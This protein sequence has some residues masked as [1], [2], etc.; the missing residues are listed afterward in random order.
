MGQT[1][2]RKLEKNIDYD[3]ALIQMEEFITELD[4][5]R[6][7]YINNIIITRTTNLLEGITESTIDTIAKNNLGIIDK[8]K[9]TDEDK[10][11]VENEGN[12]YKNTYNVGFRIN[13]KT[14]SISNLDSTN[15]SSSAS[16]TAS[17]ISSN[18]SAKQESLINGLK[19]ELNKYFNDVKMGAL[20]KSLVTDIYIL[21]KVVYNKKIHKNIK[22]RCSPY[23]KIK[24]AGV[25]PKDIPD[26]NAYFT[27]NTSSSLFQIDDWKFNVDNKN[28]IFELSKKFKDLVNEKN[29][30]KREYL[31]K[32]ITVA[33]DTLGKNL[34][35]T[36][37][38]HKFFK[39]YDELVDNNIM[40]N[41]Y[42]SSKTSQQKNYSFVDYDKLLN[43]S[44]FQNCKN[45]IDKNILENI[46]LNKVYQIK[47]EFLSKIQQNILKE[48][49]GLFK[50]LVD[51][52]DDNNPFE[53]FYENDE[54]DK[55]YKETLF[56][57]ILLLGRDNKSLSEIVEGFF[58]SKESKQTFNQ[59]NF[60]N[61]FNTFQIGILK[62]EDLYLELLNDTKFINSKV[63]R[64][65]IDDLYR[66]CEGSY[67]IIDKREKSN[68]DI[69][70][71]TEFIKYKKP[72]MK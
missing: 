72:I 11:N 49:Y 10:T 50:E 71:K 41:I 29:I 57:K 65:Y 38:N 27:N 63:E 24:K 52:S 61:Y 46:N 8:T 34:C 19:T 39:D 13:D 31:T 17:T 1:V 43:E 3:D 20:F 64:E 68:M 22:K 45:P 7:K 14:E 30:N 70:T 67:Q 32:E 28:R 58:E 36:Y 56:D 23:K 37:P 21:Y 15:A 16:T 4:N 55:K 47:I 9:M 69:K 40:P 51:Y 44:K 53:N 35:D 48:L 33:Q 18:F 5:N 12:N 6:T 62:A 25:V 42:Y 26:E 2:S 66:T 54:L 60:T 59:E